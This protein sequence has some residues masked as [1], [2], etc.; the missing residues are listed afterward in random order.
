MIPYARLNW[1]PTCL[2]LLACLLPAAA[3]ELPLSVQPLRTVD[4]VRLLTY[5][6]A[7]MAPPV[8]LRVVVISHLPDGFDA[9]DST[10]GLFFDLRPE[11]IP[12]LG[13]SIDVYGNVTGGFYGPYIVVDQ[14]RSRGQRTIPRALN[15]RP[16]FVQTGIGDNRLIEIEGLMVDVEFD[17][18]QRSGQGLIVNGQTD[19]RI[20]FQNQNDE[21][22]SERIKRLVGS[23][24]RLKGSGAPL[25]NDGRQRIGSDI[26]C[27]SNQF[28]EVVNEGLTTQHVPLGDI[29]RWDSRSAAPGLVRTL[30]VVTLVEGPKSLIVQSGEHGARVKTLRDHDATPGDT[31]DLKGLPDTEGYFVG[32]RYA[33][34]SP[35]STLNEVATPVIED[36]SL[37][38]ENAFQLV[39]VSGTMIEREGRILNLESKGNLIPVSLSAFMTDKD[40]PA[41]GSEIRI[42]GV[43][44]VDADQRGQLRSATVA[45]RSLADLEIIA[46]PS[47][48]NPR[49]YWTAI[50]VLGAGIMLVLIWTLALNRRVTTQTT[51][52]ESQI[53]SNA[54]LEERNRIAR[55]LHDTFSQGFAGVGYQLASIDNHL[56]T[57][58]ARAREKLSAA[59]EMVEHSLAETRDSLTGLRV[60]TAAESLEFPTSMLSIMEERCKEASIELAV[61]MP[62]DLNQIDLNTET[63]YACHRIMLEALANTIKHSGAEH[64]FIDL[65]RRN[66]SWTFSVRDDGSGFD[67]QNT[68]DIGHYGLQGMKER[69]REIKAAFEVDSSHQGTCITL[70]LAETKL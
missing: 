15:F 44:L 13:E 34:I 22:Q 23:W 11:E 38:R 9:Q 56:D 26:I 5:A 63:A 18:N 7:R 17:E 35:S 41:A 6:E 25:F 37:S 45:M 32:L 52:I 46:T 12:P 51:L 30:G 53:Q 55:E 48:W 31:L 33:D 64:L 69:A 40:L 43:K 39:T 60:P 67:L 47:W 24:I 65:E 4:E 54:A 19:L 8:L 42:T 57:D 1:K 21:F 14:I 58:P 16:D 59:R 20:R 10:G 36:S 49:R 62:D 2:A 28:I 29:G 68:P 50:F 3:D 70:T 61:K 27:S 66:S